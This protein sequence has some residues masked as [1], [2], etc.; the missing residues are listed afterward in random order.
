MTSEVDTRYFDDEFTA[1][2]ITLTPPD[3]C[4]WLLGPLPP[5]SAPWAWLWVGGRVY[6]LGTC[7]RGSL[8][9]PLRIS[10]VSAVGPQGP[11]EGAQ[12]PLAERSA[13]RHSVETKPFPRESPSRWW[14][15]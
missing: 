3:R 1:Q 12:E 8:K 11:G 6:D 5:P 15:V 2:S 9:F 13:G 4:E 14:H 10:V 7:L